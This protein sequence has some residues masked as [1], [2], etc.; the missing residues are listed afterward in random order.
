MTKAQVTKIPI[1]TAPKTYTP[2]QH[3]PLS[4]KQEEILNRLSDY[5][6]EILLTD[7]EKAWA[8]EACLQRYL[9]ASKWHL[10]EAMERIKCSLEWRRTYKPE[11]IDPKEVEPE[12]NINL[13]E[14]NVTDYRSSINIGYIISKIVNDTFNI[15][16]PTKVGHW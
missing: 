3:P 10:D 7:S 2:I 16:S 11:H 4:V 14:N 1:L 12:V 15:L 5:V 9:R 8:N 13:N 6:N